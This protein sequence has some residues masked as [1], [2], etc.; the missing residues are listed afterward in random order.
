[1]DKK[2]GKSSWKVYFEGNFWGHHS[3][4]HAGKEIRIEKEFDWAGHHWL[5]PAVYSC[6]KGLVI[7]F[8]MR[9]SVERIRGFMEKWN[10][11]LENASY[12]NFTKEQQM[13]M[14]IENPLCLD[15]RP[16][17][18]L[19]G[20]TLRMSHSCR[21]SFNPCLSEGIF[22]ELETKEVMEYYGLDEA[23]GWVIGRSVFSWTGSHRPEIKK[24]FL[25]MEQMPVQIPGPHFSVHESGDTFTFVHPVS[26]TKYTLTVEEIEQQSIFEKGF[27]SEGW[28][29]P[30][31]C[32]GMS[33]TMSPE[34]DDSIAIFDCYEGDKPME[35]RLDENS[36]ESVSRGVR[37]VAVIG[38]I[39][40][41]VT[42][43]PGAV[44]HRKL[45]RAYSALHFETVKEDVEWRIVF[46][47]K[48][49]EAASFGLI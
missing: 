39:N 34:T 38:G 18:E 7:D 20:N 24:L 22:H 4:E 48:Q 6:G 19:N 25:R 36:L 9:V 30:R 12:E 26:G 31:H 11:S 1:M 28:L 40:E 3:K 8:C 23:F 32:L 10:L 16:C 47:V 21:L 45:H 13:Q 14:E 2:Y 46:H 5:V 27:D 44:R 15:F 43:L 29:Y 41:P 33:Y 49:F 42:I 35:I 17:I 37:S